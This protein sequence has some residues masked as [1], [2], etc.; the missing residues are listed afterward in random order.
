MRKKNLIASA[1][2]SRRKVQNRKAEKIRRER[3]KEE[4]STMREGGSEVNTN[5][6]KS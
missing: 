5:T 6:N 4:H 1:S 3:E 2:V